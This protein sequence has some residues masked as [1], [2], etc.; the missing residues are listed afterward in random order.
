MRAWS[1]EINRGAVNLEAREISCNWGENSKETENEA[2]A[3]RFVCLCISTKLIE[4]SLLSVSPD[5]WSTPRCALC[6]TQ[7]D[8]DRRHSHTIRVAF[9]FH[10]DSVSC[11]A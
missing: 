10:K 9:Y 8:K 11:A 3:W 5:S 7:T 4:V 2:G 6:W 1:D